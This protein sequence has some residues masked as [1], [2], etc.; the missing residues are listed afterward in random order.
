MTIMY[1]KVELFNQHIYK[2]IDK[3][4]TANGSITTN[5]S[6]AVDSESQ[7]ALAFAYQVIIL[8]L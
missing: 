2:S 4:M 6:H 1:T 5:G 7:D 3:K 8:L